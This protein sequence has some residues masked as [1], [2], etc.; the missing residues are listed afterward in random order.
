MSEIQDAAISQIREVRH[1]ISEQ[2]E[3]DP[4]RVV[5]Y[6]LELQRKFVKRLLPDNHIEETKSHY[7][8]ASDTNT[9]PSLLPLKAAG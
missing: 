7:A 4:Q 3:H 6:Y 1:R 2:Q 9:T 8:V 5:D